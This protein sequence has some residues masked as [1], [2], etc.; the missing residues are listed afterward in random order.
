MYRCSITRVIFRIYAPYDNFKT[1]HM[2]P[3]HLTLGKAFRGTVFFFV[4]LFVRMD[5]EPHSM[6]KRMLDGWS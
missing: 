6:T 1:F 4:H 5:Y 3:D 2:V